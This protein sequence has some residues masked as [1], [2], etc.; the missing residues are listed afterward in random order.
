M[1]PCK[2]YQFLLLLS[3]AMLFYC[4]PSIVAMD[5][6]NIL[7]Q[8]QQTVSELQQK[9]ADLE[10]EV[11]DLKNVS[12]MDPTAL[13][14]TMDEFNELKKMVDSLMSQQAPSNASSPTSSF[15]RP[16]TTDNEQAEQLKKLNK[17]LERIGY[18]IC[19]AHN[20]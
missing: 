1:R 8:G 15:S 5:I 12:P 13:Q 16:S 4:S 17:I 14:Q 20:I 3:C 11:R 10:K 9:V 19:Q 2:M 6:Q 7:T 18:G